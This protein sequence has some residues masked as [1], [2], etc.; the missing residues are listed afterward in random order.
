MLVNITGN[1]DGHILGD[2][3][4]MTCEWGNNPAFKTVTWKRSTRQEISSTVWIFEG[5]GT[6]VHQQTTQFV[7][8]FTAVE[9]DHY[10]ARHLLVLKG[11]TEE[12]EGEYWCELD[13][14]TEH[15]TSDRRM[16]TIQ[17]GGW[18]SCKIFTRHMLR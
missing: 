18:I 11:I 6:H 17:E 9:S 8:K 1:F 3:I 14:L 5:N 12:D 7:D 13:I 16:L 10:T 2:D 4:V 15:V